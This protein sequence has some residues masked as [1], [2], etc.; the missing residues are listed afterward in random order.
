MTFSDIYLK[1]FNSQALYKINLLF[2]LNK[3]F[4]KTSGSLDSKKEAIKGQGL[5]QP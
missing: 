4:Q 1:V 5:T 2:Y 3:N